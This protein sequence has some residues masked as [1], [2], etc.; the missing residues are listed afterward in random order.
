[1]NIGNSK[2]LVLIYFRDALSNLAPELQP[3]SDVNKMRKFQ[4]IRKPPPYKFLKTFET[5]KG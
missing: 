1:M 5:Q 2:R 3:Q 4:N